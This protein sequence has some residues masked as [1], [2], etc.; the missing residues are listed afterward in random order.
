MARKKVT[1]PNT[2][3]LALSEL[4][5]EQRQ[6]EGLS[7]STVVRRRF[8]QHTAAVVS[9]IILA[10]IVLLAFTSVGTIIGGSGRLAAD[11]ASVQAGALA[12]LVVT[13]R[14]VGAAAGRQG[15]RILRG[16]KPGAIAP[17]V[18]SRPQIQ[19]NLVAAKKQGVSLP[20]ALLKNSTVIV[21]P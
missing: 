18:I 11:T 6:I 19:L 15:I 12:A 5:I 17:E 8:F 20:E 13:E 21:K 16:A 2:E 7:L 9:M 1:A 14:D 3:Q 4:T 10:L